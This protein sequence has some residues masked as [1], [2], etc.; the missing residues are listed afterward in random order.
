MNMQDKD[1]SGEEEGEEAYFCD[2]GPD[3]RPGRREKERRAKIINRT[4]ET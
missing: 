4:G 1:H 3:L 2:P